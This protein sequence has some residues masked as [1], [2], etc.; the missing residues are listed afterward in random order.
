MGFFFGTVLY[1]PAKL[2]IRCGCQRRVPDVIDPT[3]DMHPRG[4]NLLCSSQPKNHGQD[5]RRKL[6]TD[7]VC[8]VQGPKVIQVN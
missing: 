4:W 2:V 8:R 3:R 1:F 7:L 5:A 6:Q